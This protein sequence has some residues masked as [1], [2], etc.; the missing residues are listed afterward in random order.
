MGYSNFTYDDQKPEVRRI[1][2]SYAGSG[3]IN[4]A[5]RK[6]IISVLGREKQLCLSSKKRSTNSAE[7][8]YIS[9]VFLDILTGLKELES[10]DLSYTSFASLPFAIDKMIKLKRLLLC[11][12]NITALPHNIG[13]LY[14]LQILDVSCS[15][16]KEL[17]ISI[18]YLKELQILD[19]SNTAIGTLPLSIGSLTRLKRF[20]L[21]G[22]QINELPYR[23]D[24]ILSLQELDLSNTRISELPFR[25]GYLSGLTNLNLCNT[26]L[27]ELPVRI[28]NLLKLQSLDL[29]LTKIR[30]L[31]GFIGNMTALRNL[32]ISKTMVGEL[33]ESL[34][35]LSSLQNLD[36]SGTPI[37]KLPENFSEL[38]GLQRLNLSRTQIAELPEA[39]GRLPDLKILA[40]EELELTELPENLLMLNLPFTD[41]KYLYT[42]IPGIYIHGIRLK[43]QP[44]EI[45]SQSRELIL[46]YFKSNKTSIP[47]NEC[48]IVFLGDGEAGKSLIISRLMHDG[49]LPHDFKGDSTPGI[50]IQSK[51]Y[52]IGNEKIELHFWDFGGQAIM[53]SMHRLF[54]TN[55][56]LYVVVVN[57]RDNKANEQAWY[58]I[59]N[60]KSFVNGAPVLLLVNKKD[61]NPS[62]NVNQ[63]GLKKEYENLKEVRI[64]SALKSTRNEFN[65]E[66]RDVICRL[67]SE[68]DT[69]HTPFSRNWLS[70]MHDLQEMSDDYITSEE[71]YLKCESNRINTDRKILDQLISW[72]QDLGV[73]FYSRKHPVA[74]QYMVL[75]PRWLLN[76]LYIL[77]FNGRVFA[78][79]GVIREEDIFTLICESVPDKEV[80]KVWSDI[81]YKINEVQYIINVLQN[82]GLIYRLDENQFFLPMLCNED[83]YDAVKQFEVEDV[84]HICY[85]YVYLPEN[86][87]HCL[88]VLHGYELNTDAVWRTGAVLERKNCKL[89]ALIRIRENFLDIFVKTEGQ[90]KYPMIVY[91]D[92]IRDSVQT[93]NKNFSLNAEEYIYYRRGTDEELFDYKTLIGSKE[94][95]INK[96][97]SKVF[98]RAIFIDEILGIINN[99]RDHLLKD[100]VGQ[101]LS[102]LTEMSERSVDL[103][104]RGEVVLTR[105]FQTAIAPVLNEKYGIQIAREYTLG[106]AKVKIGETDLYFFRYV[107]GKKEQLFILENKYIQNFTSQ[108]LQLMGYLNPDFTAGFTLSINKDKGWEE[109]FDYICEKLEGLKEKGGTFAPV[110]IV[111]CVEPNRTQYVKTEHIVPETGM[112]MVVYHLVLQ[113]SDSERH[114]IA[115]EARK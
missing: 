27:I 39:L 101:M 86:V 110:S 30:E 77:V 38:K 105:D 89:S 58:W 96:V 28:G 67:V 40:L 78:V 108:Y 32:D 81:D 29:R 59:R 54:L 51:K 84:L 43:N 22:T 33:P 79:N 52:T 90:D 95:N 15:Q 47:I 11:Y 25:I 72:F 46:E 75:K 45:F 87:L 16:I 24:G 21:N 35:N 23:I 94:N 18:G 85:E 70:L 53:H 83:E 93:I 91:L 3:Y 62:V 102:V 7:K 50:C 48:K 56:T 41:N 115:I 74:S 57:A 19:L 20:I 65:L 66:I 114:K 5:Q 13:G 2:E 9:S 17:P 55:R 61:Q 97:F 99:P 12:S 6:E 31:P 69:V 49:E 109:A 80:K 100:V 4:E 106:R 8:P 73:C 44:L 103:A 112:N 1:I 64:V 104:G 71:F 42:P 82:F 88:M 37:S 76:A 68:M 10:L 34:T 26:P 113:I 111:R 63:T 107:E 36:L 60:I 92:M 14:N 98:Q